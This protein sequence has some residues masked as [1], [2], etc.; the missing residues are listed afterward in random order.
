MQFI[1]VC[2]IPEG[3]AGIVEAE[4]NPVMGIVEEY[5]EVRSQTFF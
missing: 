5:L 1:G 2:N 3:Y 4:T